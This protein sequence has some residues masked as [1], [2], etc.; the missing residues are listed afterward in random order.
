MTQ[1]GR[2]LIDGAPSWIRN[3]KG[4]DLLK[5]IGAHI[6]LF[7][8]AIVYSCSTRFASQKGQNLGL[9]GENRGLQR[10]FQESD[11]SYAN[12]LRPWRAEHSRRGTGIALLNQVKIAMGTNI[13]NTRLIY[14]N[15]VKYQLY[16]DGSIQRGYTDEFSANGD[17]AQWARWWLI[18]EGSVLD[19]SVVN[20]LRVITQEWNAAHCI[21]TVRILNGDRFWNS[22]KQ[23]NT[24]DSWNSNNQSLLW[25][26]IG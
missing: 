12:R 21:G 1:Y 17:A 20:S 4:T 19:P 6:D 18:V 23:W 14:R 8:D 10:G 9:I 25:T 11:D 2:R 24:A 3:G 13:Q 22:S 26:V 7:A 16:P 15:G 5:A